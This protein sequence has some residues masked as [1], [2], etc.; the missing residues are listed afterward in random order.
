MRTTGNWENRPRA[1]LPWCMGSEYPLNLA[2][3]GGGVGSGEEG[4]VVGSRPRAG[5]G[6]RIWRGGRFSP[7]RKGCAEG[8]GR[9]SEYCEIV[10]NVG[11]FHIS[12]FPHVA[13]P[14]PCPCAR[15]C[16]QLLHAIFVLSRTSLARDL[17]L[18]ALTSCTRFSS[19]RAVHGGG[20]CS[21]SRPRGYI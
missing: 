9:V 8:G 11:P 4:R 21:C 16:K 1:F 12:A 14:Y 13:P 20:T 2:L 7:S 15:T 19:M 5:G 17:C 3:A 10:N 6:G 18:C